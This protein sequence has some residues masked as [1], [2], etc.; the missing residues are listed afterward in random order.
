MILT[1]LF[2]VFQEH[3]GLG[4]PPL[5]MLSAQCN[6]L[7][8]RITSL[9][10]KGFHPWKKPDMT[11]QGLQFTSQGLPAVN[12]RLAD[13]NLASYP[14][15]T[16]S[17]CAMAYGNNGLI[18]Q[19]AGANSQGQESGKV[20]CES[21]GGWNNGALQGMPGVYSRIP[22]V[23][24][25]FDSWPVVSQTSAMPPSGMTNIKSEMTPVTT[26]GGSTWWDV[27]SVGSG[28]MSDVSG[29]SSPALHPSL[30]ASYPGGAELGGITGLGAAGSSAFVTPGQHLFPEGYKAMLPGAMN[31]FTSSMQN[32]ARFFG[33]SGLS[34]LGS[35]RAQR[36][37]TGRSTCDCPNCQ[38]VDRLGPAGSALRKRNVH[39]CHIPGCGKVYNKTSHLKAHL[40]WH[41]GERPF[42]CNWLF[43]GKRFTRSDELQRHIRTHTGEK[44]FVCSICSKRFMRSDHLSKH[45]KTHSSKKSTTDGAS[46]SGIDSERSDISDCSTKGSP[47]SENGR[48]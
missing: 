48:K 45:V 3:V 28:W 24:G 17:S 8:N 41:T 19:C 15:T 40:R 25:S 18:H 36:R 47:A 23:T 5:S 13:P 10:D 35:A 34:A 12:S 20:G 1:L 43:C 21:T 4:A 29:A 26:S 6:K 9:P 42:V 16:M 2:V 39:T 14:K 27:H 33:A 22:A 32:H 31:G 11:S 38:E 37:Y 30:P 46:S 44:R 7:S